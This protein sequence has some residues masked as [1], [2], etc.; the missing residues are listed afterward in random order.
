MQCRSSQRSYNM[1]R[2]L[3][4]LGVEKAVN[5]SASC[6]GFSTEQYANDVLQG[7]SPIVTEYNFS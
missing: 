2:A 1:V 6:L 4:Q 3:G 5:M 7:R